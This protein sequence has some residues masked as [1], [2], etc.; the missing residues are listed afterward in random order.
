M[1]LALALLL[2][3]WLSFAGAPARAAEGGIAVVVGKLP[4]APTALGRAELLGIYGRKRELW[5]D[6]TPIVAINLPASHPLRRD[7]SLWLFRRTPQDLQ[8]YWND[9]YFHGVL[10]PP[11][12]ASEEAVLRFVAATPGAVGY[13][14]LCAVDKRVDVVAVLP[15]SEPAAACPSH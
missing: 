3:L 14:S 11:V 6:R 10:P 12:L 7:F 1:R 15:A 9:Q 8:S 2:L 13:V 5:D 4:G